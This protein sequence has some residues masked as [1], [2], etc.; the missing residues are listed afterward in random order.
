MVNDAHDGQT[1]ASELF[2][3]HERQLEAERAYADAWRDYW[4]ARAN[5]EAAVGGPLDARP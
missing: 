5:L 3:A 2:S 1:S 4:I